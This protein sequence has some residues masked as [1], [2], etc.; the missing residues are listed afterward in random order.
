MDIRVN[1]NHIKW[2]DGLRGLAILL[3][4]LGHFFPIFPLFK[5]GWVGVN[6]FFILSGYLITGR[7]FVHAEEGGGKFYFRNFYWRRFLRI[8]PLYYGCLIIFFGLLPLV[9]KRY[10]VHF[11]QLYREQ[12]WYWTYLSNWRIVMYGMSDNS[13]LS[14]MWSLAVEEQFYLVWPFIFLFVVRSNKKIVVVLGALLLAIVARVLA[15]QPALAYFS[16]LTASEPLLIG[17]LLCILEKE[18]RLPLSS[19]LLGAL[20]FPAILLLV[21][22]LLQNPDLDLWNEGLIRWGYTCIDI[23]FSCLLYK[24]VVVGRYTRLLRSVFSA[25]WIVWMGRYS[26]GIYL[27]NWF[28]IQMLVIRWNGLLKA[29]GFGDGASLLVS[30]VAGIVVLLGCSWLSFRY[31]ESKFLRLKNFVS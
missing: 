26:Y 30:S 27:F 15:H 6:L 29:M 23:L 11:G 2:L 20:V 9:Y 5:I 25:R 24:L 12:W 8:F 28:V 22:I 10:F 16:T 1:E 13:I 14:T 21:F 19:R 7:L 18:G 31:F 17:S 4:L 3:V